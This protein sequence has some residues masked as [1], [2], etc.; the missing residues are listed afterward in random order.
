MAIQHGH[1]LHS[2]ED[3]VTN[4]FGM[5]LSGVMALIVL[6]G[7]SCVEILLGCCVGGFP[8]AVGHCEVGQAGQA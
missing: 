1:V 2:G 7:V 5:V 8:V 6:W 3:D 4:P